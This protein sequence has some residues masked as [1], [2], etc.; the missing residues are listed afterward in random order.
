MIPYDYAAAEVLLLGSAH[1]LIRGAIKGVIFADGP[2]Q[3]RREIIIE[4]LE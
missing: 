3:G 1:E 4:E 2:S